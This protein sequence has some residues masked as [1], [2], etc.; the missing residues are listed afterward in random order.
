MFIN[1]KKKVWG[2]GIDNA[3]FYDK[4][5]KSQILLIAADNKTSEVNCTVQF[6]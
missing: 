1:K 2:G 3:G 4:T 5:A 6:V